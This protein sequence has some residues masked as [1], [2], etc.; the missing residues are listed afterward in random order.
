MI[1]IRRKEE[2]IDVQRRISAE[3]K[4]V[5]RLI[6]SVSTVLIELFVFLLGDLLLRLQPDRLNRVDEFAIQ[7][8]R[9]RDEA[10]ILLDDILDRLRLSELLR[11]LLQVDH[12]L[13]A[14]LL[15]ICFLNG[16]AGLA[17]A[18]PLEILSLRIPRMG[19]DLDLFSSHEDRVETDSELTNDGRIGVALFLKRLKK[20]LRARASDGAEV[21]GKLLAIH[22]D[23]VIG[24]GDRA[25]LLIRGD[26][27]LK[28]EI[29][30]VD[31]ILSKL[32]EAKLLERIGSIR[33]QLAHENLFIS[34]DRV[35]DDIEKLTNFGLERLGVGL[36][37]AHE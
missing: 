28:W 24:E 7:I 34:V 20:L 1:L 9:E 21:I 2:R 19:E 4:R 13:C 17:V 31:A 15:R 25:R 12:D 23:A 11:I 32:L 8:Q 14:A 36:C 26:V 10:G 29:A 6:G 35:D 18:I 27:D 33:D 3:V 30:L 22:P 5:T 37:F 16:V